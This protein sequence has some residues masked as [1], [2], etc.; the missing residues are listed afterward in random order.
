LVGIDTQ[1]TDSGN[2]TVLD[3]LTELDSQRSLDIGKVILS[4]LCILFIIFILVCSISSCIADYIEGNELPNN[5]LLLRQK[6][7]DSD[8]IRLSV[9]ADSQGN[10]SKV[11]QLSGEKASLKSIGSRE[12]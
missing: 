12:R 1:I 3:Q 7:H 11:Q 6:Q 5:H 10:Y 2:K 9:A 4:A 8:L